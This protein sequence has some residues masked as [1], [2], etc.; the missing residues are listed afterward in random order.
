MRSYYKI[1][2]GQ[3]KYGDVNFFALVYKIQPENFGFEIAVALHS[4]FGKKFQTF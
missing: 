1:P 4:K 2:D 3:K